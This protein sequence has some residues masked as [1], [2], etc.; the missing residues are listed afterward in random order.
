MHPFM[1]AAAIGHALLIAVVAFFILFAAQKSSGFVRTLGNLLGW[2]F[3]AGAAIALAGGL[4]HVATGKGPMWHH[5]GPGMMGW[6]DGD[7]MMGPPSATTAPAT[8]P[9]AAAPAPKKP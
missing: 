8:A 5:G 6:H 1:I 2:I 4:Y 9:P 7:H 3:L